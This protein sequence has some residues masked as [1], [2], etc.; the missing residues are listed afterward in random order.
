MKITQKDIV[1]CVKKSVRLIKEHQD[2]V[3]NLNVALSIIE[4][5]W[6]SG[7]DLWFINIDNRRKDTVNQKMK[8]PYYN[9]KNIK[10][11]ADHWHRVKDVGNSAR[12]ANYVGYVLING[13]TL[14]EALDSLR[15]PTVRLNTWAKEMINRDNV[16]S[17][18]GEMKAIID[19]CQHF[20]SRAYMTI[21]KRSISEINEYLTA[22]GLSTDMS[23]KPFKS[24]A[25]KI[26]HD[27]N[28]G[29]YN[30][31]LMDCDIDDDEI[32]GQLISYLKSNN[33][34]ASLNFKSQDGMHAILDNPKLYKSIDLKP[35]NL[36][37]K[38]KNK[39]N[40]KA[41]S[42]KQDGKLLV[43]S[44]CGSAYDFKSMFE[45]KYLVNES[46]IKHV[47]N[48]IIAKFLIQELSFR[49]TMGSKGSLTESDVIDPKQIFAKSYQLMDSVKKSKK[50]VNI[51][52]VFENDL[53]YKIWKNYVK[54]MLGDLTYVDAVNA[55]TKKVITDPETGETLKEPK[56]KG[57]KPQDTE[58]KFPKTA[59]PFFKWL[60]D[61]KD[62]KMKF[63]GKPTPIKIFKLDDENML[64]GHWVHFDSNMLNNPFV[65][66]MGLTSNIDIRTAPKDYFI[67]SYI[68][69]SSPVKLVKLCQEL[70]NY[71]NVILAV[72][73]DMAGMLER[74]GFFT[75]GK[76]HKV[77]YA[78]KL[79]DKKIFA[80]SE[81]ALT[82]AVMAHS[83]VPTKT[84]RRP[85]R[86]RKN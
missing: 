40:D 68:A 1:E 83:M 33:I 6:E 56:L 43:Y 54:S 86:K 32:Q 3:N 31:G 74:G 48:E 50:V 38:T 84:G 2:V 47:V 78:K 25:G 10:K 12:N 49:N 19:V 17:N 26:R 57:F 34:D 45:N 75:D 59:R 65:A 51:E 14:E 76:I 61:I 44:P 30:L 24:E 23:E 7:D 62:G 5:Q 64:F 9:K 22:N 69:V 42:I 4:K 46:K 71:N 8:H 15:N 80:T 58:Q 20:Y 52:K 66:L 81:E 82:V 36:R 55:K 53:A 37:D 77:V 11:P 28:T 72:T 27:D 79:V 73:L 35:F 41:V 60:S 13:N 16:T 18:D 85:V 67:A 70:S 39:K 29:K 21:N 63:G